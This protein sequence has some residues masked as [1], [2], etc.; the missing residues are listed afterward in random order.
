M[1]LYSHSR[2]YAMVF[3]LQDLYF[4]G[5]TFCRAFEVMNIFNRLAIPVVACALAFDFR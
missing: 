1:F 3:L 4:C 2:I 5:S